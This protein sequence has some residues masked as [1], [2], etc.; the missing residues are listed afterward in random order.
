MYSNNNVILVMA[1]NRG[2]FNLHIFLCLKK[3]VDLNLNTKYS[4]DIAI[5]Q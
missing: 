3:I 4:K 5:D 1:S 2:I